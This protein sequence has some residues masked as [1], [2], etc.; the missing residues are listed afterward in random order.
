MR[1]A[2]TIGATDASGETVQD[3]P[4]SV[5]DLFRSIYK[6]LRIDANKE[7]LSPIGRPIKFV[8]GGAAVDELF[9]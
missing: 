4:V 8:E 5:S 1:G 7:Y 6:S 3:R 9:A 2:Q